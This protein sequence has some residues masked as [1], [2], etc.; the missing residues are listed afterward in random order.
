M[1]EFRRCWRRSGRLFFL[2]GLLLASLAAIR[3]GGIAFLG[4]GVG[5]VARL[6]V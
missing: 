6:C 3:R 2:R 4:G 1:L 5:L